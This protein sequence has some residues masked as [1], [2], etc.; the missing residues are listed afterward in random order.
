M[1]PV[2]SILI[3]TQGRAPQLQRLLDSLVRLEN[4]QEIPHEISSATTLKVTLAPR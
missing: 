1:Q 2:V 3:A 4:H